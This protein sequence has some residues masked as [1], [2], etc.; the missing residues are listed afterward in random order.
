MMWEE[1]AR[2]SWPFAVQSCNG[3]RLLVLLAQMHEERPH[4]VHVTPLGTLTV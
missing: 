2:E 3:T 1:P 4:H